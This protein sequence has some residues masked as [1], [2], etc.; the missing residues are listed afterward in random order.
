MELARRSYCATTACELPQALLD[1][2]HGLDT[3]TPQTQ[4]QHH[5]LHKARS[6][7]GQSSCGVHHSKAQNFSHNLTQAKW[8]WIVHR[9]L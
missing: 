6:S 7:R 3:M 5:L 1:A 9:Q 8:E 2:F 4:M